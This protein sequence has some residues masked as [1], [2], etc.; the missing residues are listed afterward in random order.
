MT[1]IATFAAAQA[2][3][4]H[5]LNAQKAAFDAQRQT[6]TGKRIDDLKSAGRDAEVIT[7][8]RAAL[9]R[10]DSY[11][12]SA[13]R[14]A[15]RLNLQAQ[16]FDSLAEAAS[17][18]RVALT[19]NDGAFLME[20]VRAAYIK[21]SEAVNARYAGTYI[22]GG[23][24]GDA[25]PLVALSLNDL[26]AA[27]AVGDAFQNA[28]SPATVRLGDAAVV[29]TGFLASDVAG[30][31]FS[32]FKRIAEFDAGPDGPFDDPMTPAQKA[33][34]QAE[35]ASAIEAM[36]T[37]TRY[38][39]AGGAMQQ[40]VESII[41]NQKDQGIYL[42]NLI[43]GLEDADMA[44]ALARLQ[45]AQTAVEVSAATFASLKQVSLLPFLR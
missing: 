23:T 41:E 6:A 26:A 3:L 24:R 8:A 11:A 18:L 34:L 25:A 33:F 44:Q 15:N 31:L 27:P 45:Q 35:I 29:E 30:E 17:D 21:A 13:T 7:A 32:V 16:A 40:R 36:E 10:A 9:A 42:R 38:Q 5:L 20:T 37:V 39:A 1:R 2:S 14:I 12:E 22:F 43:G 19:T 4:N 28:S